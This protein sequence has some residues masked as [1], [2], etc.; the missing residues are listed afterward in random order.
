MMDSIHSS[1]LLS[2]RTTMSTASMM[3]TATSMS[4][5]TT[6]TSSQSR[7]YSSSSPKQ[8]QLRVR[9]L[10]DWDADDDTCLPIRRGQIIRVLNKLDSGWWDGV[11]DATGDRGWFPFNF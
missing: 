3:S 1:H 4:S 7:S 10:F 5:T 9:A 2:P 8:T 11:I 6:R